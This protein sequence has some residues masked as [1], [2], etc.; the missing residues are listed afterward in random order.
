MEEFQQELDMFVSLRK[1]KLCKLLEEING[2]KR[3]EI[4]GNTNLVIITI[5]DGISRNGY[6]EKICLEELCSEFEINEKTK[7]VAIDT[8]TKAGLIVKYKLVK[9]RLTCHGKPTGTYCND[10]K[11]F[12]IVP[13]HELVVLFEKV[14]FSISISKELIDSLHV[15]YQEEMKKLEIKSE[16]VLTGYDLLIKNLRETDDEIEQVTLI[17]NSFREGLTWT[18]DM[19]KSNDLQKYVDTYNRLCLNTFGSN[20]AKSKSKPKTISEKPLIINNK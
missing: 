17:H 2:R 4:L 16:P 15:K 8:L 11:L 20:N 5:L 6:I 12:A 10:L 18:M 19:I 13:T 3:V 9:E 14:G 1:S 7:R